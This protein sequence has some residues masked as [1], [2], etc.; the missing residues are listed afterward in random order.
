[1]HHPPDQTWGLV[2]IIAIVILIAC[3][4]WALTFEPKRGGGGAPAPKLDVDT[5]KVPKTK[6]PVSV[7]GKPKR[8]SQRGA[9]WL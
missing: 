1:M 8:R 5:S 6:H 3:V 9:W 2:G 7:T 4:G